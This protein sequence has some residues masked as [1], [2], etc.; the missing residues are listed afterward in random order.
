M[1]SK[2][3][4]IAVA[5]RPGEIWELRGMKLGGVHFEEDCRARPCVIHSPTDHVMSEWE[6][7]WR[8]DRAIF[9]RVCEHGIGHPDPD[10]FAYWVQAFGQREADAMAVH[11]CDMCCWGGGDD[12]EEE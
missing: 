9:E 1:K 5:R 8:T 12:G 6:L 11:G 4:K 10:Q 7:I 3:K 2:L